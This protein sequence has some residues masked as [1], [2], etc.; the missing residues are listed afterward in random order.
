LDPTGAVALDEYREAL[1]IQQEVTLAT[2]IVSHD[3][4]LGAIGNLSQ[5]FRQF[6]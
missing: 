3:D 1:A 5:K 4:D 2:M 6:V